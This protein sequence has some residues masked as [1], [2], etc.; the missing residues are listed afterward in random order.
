VNLSHARPAVCT[1]LGNHVGYTLEKQVRTLEPPAIRR[2]FDSIISR[3]Y[4]SPVDNQY[5]GY[6]R[7]RIGVPESEI[8][9]E[10]LGDHLARGSKVRLLPVGNFPDADGPG[11]LRWALGAVEGMRGD[12]MVSPTAADRWGYQSPSPATCR[13]GQ[14]R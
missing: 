14:E 10:R 1:T 3:G 4:H 6:Q 9:R 5:L 13:R 11:F 8:G 2:I 12:S 7:P